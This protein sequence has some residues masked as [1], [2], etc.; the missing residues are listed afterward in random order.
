MIGE[1]ELRK[2]LFEYLSQPNDHYITS[3]IANLRYSRPPDQ[4]NFF[5]R[6][7]L[8]E[9]IETVQKLLDPNN[10]TV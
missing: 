9:V 7:N 4:S 3:I 8:R 1:R 5:R 10:V 6:F 2:I